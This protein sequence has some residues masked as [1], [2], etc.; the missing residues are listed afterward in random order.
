MA[1]NPSYLSLYQQG[2]LAE[3]VRVG[4][5]LLRECTVC[6]R[7]CHVN[8]F[9]SHAGICRTN[10]L[11]VVTAYHPHFGE[12][13]I[14]V[15]Q[16]GSGAIFLT[17]C[18]LRCVFCQNW[19]I[20]HLRLGTEISHPCLAEMMVELQAIGCHNINLVTPTHMV[21]QILAALPDAIEMGLSLP[22]V[23]N[24]GGYDR[25][26]T[27]R[28]LDGVIDI[29]MPD[30][31]YMDPRHA[32]RYSAAADY[33]HVVRGAVKEMHRQ[34]GDLVMDD[35][36]LAVRGLLVRHLIMPGGVADT[37]Q[38][39]R[40]LAQEVSLNTYVNLMDQY[41]PYGRADSYPEIA[42]PITAEEFE[43]ALE[44]TRP[45]GIHRLDRDVSRRFQ[46]RQQIIHSSIRQQRSHY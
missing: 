42:R 19:E 9:E 36:G 30:V 14:L 13:A 35:E 43:E 4:Q 40:F 23:Y 2:I 20:S 3:R 12:E 21:P 38:V 45:E 46:Q 1:T 29:Y 11:P 17:S 33:P 24:T 16:H 7:L 22:L 18:S 6:P 26:E 15:G 25:V 31:K 10:A 41:W 37:R 8:R 27:L 28:L 44:A 5:E 34:V 32:G 39:M